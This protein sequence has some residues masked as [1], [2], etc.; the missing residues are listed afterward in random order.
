VDVPVQ[1][2]SIDAQ[3][4]R[5]SLVTPEGPYAS[6]EVVASTGSTNA[7]LRLAAAEGALDR[8]VLIAEEQTAG[9]GRR[10][11]NWSSPKGAGIYLSILLRPRGVSFADAGSLSIVAGLALTD[12]TRKLGVDAVLKWP[13]DLL[14]G[15]DRRKC[16]GI[17]AE[18]VSSA[19]A[20]P[21][22][23]TVVVGI[24]VNVRPSL[25]HVPPAPGG[26][27]AT[28]LEEEVA[29]ELDR[30]ELISLLLGSFAEREQRWRASGGNLARAG[31]LEDYRARCA[32]IGQ[33][34]RILLPG[35]AELRG[36]VVDVDPAGQLLVTDERGRLRTVLAGDVVHLRA[37]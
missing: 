17:L 18:A 12:L 25:D 29:R 20:S 31:L 7:E 4:L 28:C 15:P 22:E 14:V 8:T 37:H 3:K 13:N 11:R 33:D 2:A 34:V 35:N 23:V 1:A 30:T 9:V 27:P 19:T 5:S 16:A 24:G 32:T 21:E 36:V 26:L 6:L 10:A